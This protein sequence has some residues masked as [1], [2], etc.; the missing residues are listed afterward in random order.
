MALTK[1]S[2]FFLLSVLLSQ[3]L[4]SS[5]LLGAEQLVI[6]SP[7]ESQRSTPALSPAQT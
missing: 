4:I 5:L 2:F 7:E 6:H 3:S 1:P